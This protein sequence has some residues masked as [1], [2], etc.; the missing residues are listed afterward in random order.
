M[1]SA[2]AILRDY[3]N[4]VIDRAQ[5]PLCFNISGKGKQQT[6]PKKAQRRAVRGVSAQQHSIYLSSHLESLLTS[7]IHAYSVAPGI[8][9][10]VSPSVNP[11]TR[12]P[13]DVDNGT[14]EW[15]TSHAGISVGDNRQTSNSVLCLFAPPL[16]SSDLRQQR[17][18]APL[19]R[20]YDWN[21][22]GYRSF[23]LAHG[24]CTHQ[25]FLLHDKYRTTSCSTLR[26]RSQ[27]PY[28]GYDA[29]LI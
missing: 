8:I 15:T 2:E 28:Y 25:C 7:D 5:L 29:P 23:L 16:T 9:P 1:V 12:D 21:S 17:S 26:I 22:F 14:V 10:A 13:Q 18:T 20:R 27:P 11:S 6:R 19:G 3:Q 24:S 4:N